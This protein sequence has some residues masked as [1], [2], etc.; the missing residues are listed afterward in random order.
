M[1]LEINGYY[2][3]QKSLSFNQATLTYRGEWRLENNFKLL[4]KKPFRYK[5]FIYKK[6]QST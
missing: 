3:A 4:K 2:A 6:R 1:W 5:S